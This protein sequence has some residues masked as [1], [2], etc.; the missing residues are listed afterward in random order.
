MSPEIVSEKKIGVNQA[1]INREVT[2]N[3]LG[4]INVQ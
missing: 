1:S 4:N 2:I 3:R